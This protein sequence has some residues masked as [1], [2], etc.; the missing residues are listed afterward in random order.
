[1]AVVS[2]SRLLYASESKVVIYWTGAP[3][4][5]TDWIAIS[6]SGSDPGSPT[7]HGW[8]YI[9][10]VTD[11]FMVFDVPTPP[12]VTAGGVTPGDWVIRLYENDTLTMLDESPVLTVSDD[13][14]STYYPEI[15]VYSA[16][17]S[18]SGSG[19]SIDGTYDP[20][21]MFTASESFCT[22]QAG[23]P[24]I[25]TLGITAA[26]DH[27]DVQFSDDV[28]LSGPALESTNWF[29]TVDGPGREVV[30]GAVSIISSDTVRLLVTPQTLNA[31]Y[32]LHLPTL[33]ISSP[34]FGIFTGLY[35]LDFEGVATPVNVQM[36]KVIDTHH[37]DVIFAIAVSDES[38]S[39]PL[40]YTI[41]N[42]LTI[43]SATKITDHWYRLRNTPRQVDAT[44]YTITISNIEPA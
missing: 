39:D 16:S 4:N 33:G 8:A 9:N 44:T 43:V 23:T 18:R 21:G 35:S 28:T 15:S 25:H 31:N 41:D 38:A 3:G 34:T 20:R 30:V 26:A 42:G 32:T 6:P 40:N 7:Y 13:K 24:T 36:I 11:G 5:M 29:I 17:S 27:L 12:H 2:T 10:G 14:D 19:V 1:V 22:C 37:I